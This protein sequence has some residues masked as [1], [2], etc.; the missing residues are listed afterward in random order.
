MVSSGL[1]G[2]AQRYLEKDLFANREELCNNRLEDAENDIEPVLGESPKL[3]DH[4][5]VYMIRPL[6]DNWIMP[7]GVF[8]SHG[9]APGDDLHRLLMSALIY[10]ET[11]GARVIAIVNDGASTNRKVWNLTDVGVSSDG[12]VKNTI[13]HPVTEN[14]VYCLQDVPHIF[15]CIRSQMF[16]HE[17][18]QVWFHD[19]LLSSIL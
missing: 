6:K 2:I 1:T 3:E 12:V 11:K 18:V 5:L 15:K 7:F 17:T 9:A 14:D 4:A 8:A 13:I 19:T 10:I 16:N